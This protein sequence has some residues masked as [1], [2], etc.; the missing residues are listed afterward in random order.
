MEK[1]LSHGNVFKFMYLSGVADYGFHFIMDL[2]YSLLCHSITPS[3]WVEG[4]L[5]L[6][7]G[8]SI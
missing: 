7:L 2:N 1:K 3:G 4:S 6:T 5:P 8:L